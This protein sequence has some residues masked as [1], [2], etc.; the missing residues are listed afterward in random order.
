V[1][2][3]GRARLAESSTVAAIGPGRFEILRE[4]IVSAA[5]LCRAGGLALTFVCTGNTCRSPMAEGLA[6]RAL[7]ARLGVAEIARFG[8]DVSSAG[9]FAAPGTPASDLAVQV[10][11]QH[12]IDLSQHTSTP[13]S[14]PSQLRRILEADRVYCM[15]ASHR[16][17]L[18]GLLP[19]G[20]SEHVTL[21]DP[22][23]GDVPDPFGGPLE[24]YAATAEAL[25]RMIDARLTADWI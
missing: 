15:T 17:A 13:V 10:L 22:D 25:G 18:L 21:L 19:P 16:E 23:G 9:V 8:F 4:G 14:N 12:G 11:A 7:T 1:L 20:K 3:G 2:E 5:D 24:Q 6:R